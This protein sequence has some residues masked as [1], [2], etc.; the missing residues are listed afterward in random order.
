MSEDRETVNIAVLPTREA[1]TQMLQRRERPEL[2]FTPEQQAMIRNTYANGASEEEFHVLLSIAKAKRL[3]PLL[4]QIH[5]IKRWTRDRGE[6]W[7]AQTG[8]DGFRSIAEDTGLYDG[9]DEPE[10]KYHNDDPDKQIVVAKVRVYRKDVSRAF[11]GVAHFNEYAQRVKDGGLTKMWAEKPH[12]MIAKCA[13]SLAMRKAFPQDL[14]DVYTSEEM[15]RAQEEHSDR[16]QREIVQDAT[17]HEERTDWLARISSATTT[18]EL[19]ALA[20]PM[21]ADKN[22]K[23]D[24]RKKHVE[25]YKARYAELRRPAP[26]EDRE[27][28][29]DG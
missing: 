26:A 23:G 10:F 22:L 20:G 6:V 2:V 7:A 12:I 11:V 19:D 3:N 24:A 1:R 29:S 21:N 17:H 13:E 28:G 9:Q 27:P 14:G 25:I 18:A 4:G 8:I 5:F 15:G 16:V